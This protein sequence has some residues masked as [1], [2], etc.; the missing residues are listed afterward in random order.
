MLFT[1]VVYH[2]SQY[3]L[4]YI[5]WGI[6]LSSSFWLWYSILTT[7]LKDGLCTEI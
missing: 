1:P 6:A 5:L 4:A 3:S 2:L 7:A